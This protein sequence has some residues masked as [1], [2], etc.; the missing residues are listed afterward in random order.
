MLCYSV[1]FICHVT[2]Y[3]AHA[4]SGHFQ[5]SISH[6]IDGKLVTKRQPKIISW[7]SVCVCVSYLNPWNCAYQTFL[8]SFCK[9]EVCS[10]CASNHNKQNC[11]EMNSETG[12]PN[13][14]SRPE[15]E[16]ATEQQCLNSEDLINTWLLHL[17]MLNWKYF[18]ITKI[19][20][21]PWC[22]I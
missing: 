4:S 11:K 3:M 13:R 18:N 7:S 2:F 16:S 21:V 22:L 1:S 10:F 6:S 19:T 20:C 14:Q 12:F 15:F 8:F 5:A 17:V 9:G